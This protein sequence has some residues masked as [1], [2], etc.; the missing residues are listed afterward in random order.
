MP[1]EKLPKGK[2]LVS[3]PVMIEEEKRDKLTYK[4]CQRIGKEALNIAYEQ[5][6]NGIKK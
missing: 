3:V 2:K 4:E 1:R 6:L 5:A